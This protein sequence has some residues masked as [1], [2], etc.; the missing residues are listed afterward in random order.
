M[1]CSRLTCVPAIDRPCCPRVREVKE[2]SPDRRMENVVRFRGSSRKSKWKWME[3]D[4]TRS[5]LYG[6][7]W[8]EDYEKRGIESMTRVRT[9]NSTSEGM[10]DGHQKQHN[11]WPRIRW[12]ADLNAS[13]AS[14]KRGQRWRARIADR[15]APSAPRRSRSWRGALG[16]FMALRLSWSSLFNERWTLWYVVFV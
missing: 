4:W 9:P 12:Q 15:L 1:I 2:R 6:R 7:L 11:P 16:L 5:R 13:G 14:T 8:A 3:M 10:D